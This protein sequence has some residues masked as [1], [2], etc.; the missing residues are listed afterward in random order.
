[1]PSRNIV[2]QYGAGTYYHIYN[3]GVN[4]QDI[5]RD[6]ADFVMFQHLLKRHLSLKPFRDIYGREIAHLRND[7]ELLAFCLMPN[8]FHILVYNKTQRGIV[9]LTQRV[10]TAYSMY[11]N[12][13]YER[14]G[15]L[16]QATY[17]ASLVYEEAYLLHISRYIHL[18]P[19]DIGEDYKSY[20][21]SSYMY[22][23]GYKRAEWLQAGRAMEL[24]DSNKHA[25]AK[26]VEDYGAMHEDIKNMKYLFADC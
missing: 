26:F 19:I 17:K 1:M 7:I 20:E 8:H 21:F 3:R 2:K 5:F 14:I 13:R 25:Y 18:N 10:M 24:Y 11:F 23:M 16:F 4:K 6:K 12:K 22:Y 9:Q 15:P